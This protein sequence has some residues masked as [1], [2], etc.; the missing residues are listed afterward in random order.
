MKG[1][2]SHHNITYWIVDNTI[3][4][5]KKEWQPTKIR[6]KKDAGFIELEEMVTLLKH[7]CIYYL[8]PIFIG[9][10][11]YSDINESNY[12]NHMML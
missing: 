5:K 7:V 8:V 6:T 12:F 2:L 11:K 3:N 4:E 9:T 10:N 1:R